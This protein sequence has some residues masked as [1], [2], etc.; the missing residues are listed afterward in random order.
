MN[1][2]AINSVEQ[3]LVGGWLQRGR[4]PRPGGGCR[5]QRFSRG[6]VLAVNVGY[7][8]GLTVVSVV[9]V[10]WL[11]RPRSLR[12]HGTHRY[13]VH[14]LDFHAVGHEGTAS[15]VRFSIVSH[16]AFVKGFFQLAVVLSG[17][18]IRN[19]L[20]KVPKKSIAG[21]RTFNNAAG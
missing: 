14:L 10:L 11:I 15:F 1:D 18:E 16:A 17:N 12:P 3:F 9:A 7:G 6:D 2:E 20:A 21:C 13:F 4:R 5:G 8:C 19:C